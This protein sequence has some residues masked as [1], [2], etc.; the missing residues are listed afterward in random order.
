[1]SSRTPSPINSRRS[2]DFVFNDRQFL[3]W[4]A[5]VIFA[6]AFS[7]AG[8]FVYERCTNERLYNSR[9][10]TFAEIPYVERID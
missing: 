8:R 1:M 4:G 3:G 7:R 6:S 10:S 9:L 5:I 2:L